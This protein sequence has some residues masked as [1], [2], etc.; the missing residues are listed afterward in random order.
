MNIW[1]FNLLNWQGVGPMLAI[2]ISFVCTGLIVWAFP[3]L[4]R[5]NL[6]YCLKSSLLLAF[7]FLLVF[8]IDQTR[9]CPSSISPL[10][11]FYQNIC[12]IDRLK[13]G[14]LELLITWGPKLEGE[15]DLKLG[16]SDPSSQHEQVCF[17]DTPAIYNDV[18]CNISQRQEVRMQI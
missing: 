4:H 18:L 13:G 8:M 14:T 15:P 2:S 16:T 10:G 17:L 9:M 3:Q 12:N 7:C 5:L 1:Q 6:T 11:V